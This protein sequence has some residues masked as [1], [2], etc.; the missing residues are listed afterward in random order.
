MLYMSQVSVL[1]ECS[2]CHPQLT[3]DCVAGPMD[4]D[5]THVRSVGCSGTAFQSLSDAE[6]LVLT[7]D[8][9]SNHSHT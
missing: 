4:P 3:F 6:T 1:R 7:V 8:S 5:Q 9:P 2:A